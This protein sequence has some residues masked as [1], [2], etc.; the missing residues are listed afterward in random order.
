MSLGIILSLC[1]HSGTWSRPFIEM[2]YQVV[3]VDPK[4]GEWKHAYNE[5][6]LTD[7]DLG[8]GTWVRMADGGW[9]LPFAT[10]TL[11]NVLRNDP[12]YFRQPVRG[13]LMAPP[14]TDFS[15]SGARHWA[16]KDADGRTAS[17][18]RIVQQCLGIKD[19]LKPDWWALE[20]P[21]GRLARLVPEVGSRRMT[22]HPH[23]YAGWADDP[24]TDAYT[25]LTC[26]WGDFETGLVR[27]EVE[28]VMFTLKNGKRGSWMFAKLGGKSERTKELRS[29]AP[30]GFS[31]AFAAAQHKAAS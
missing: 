31:R 18:I 30:L 21:S 19:L 16:G 11:L 25:K 23:H 7:G 22:F 13:I 4:H 14:C 6:G 9:G 10:L 28:P 17:S 15:G 20:N 29:I 5:R 24:A 8:D 1:D 26:L 3:R 27:R 2:G 12:A